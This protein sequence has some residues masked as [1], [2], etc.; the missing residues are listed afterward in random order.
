MLDPFVILLSPNY[1]LAK[2]SSIF[3]K[4]FSNENTFWVNSYLT[5]V[6]S[7]VNSCPLPMNDENIDKSTLIPNIKSSKF[8]LSTK[9]YNF[10]QSQ[11]FLILEVRSSFL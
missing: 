7:N 3:F 5:Q 4:I 6:S 2:S 1:K 10:S 8:L 11:K 9:K